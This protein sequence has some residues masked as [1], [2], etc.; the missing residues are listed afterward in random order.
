MSLSSSAQPHRFH[1]LRLPQLGAETLLLRDVFD[2]RDCLRVRLSPQQCRGDLDRHDLARLGPEAV[3]GGD[4]HAIPE[5]TRQTLLEVLAILCMRHRC[6]GAL[7]QLEDGVAEQAAQSGVDPREPQIGRKNGHADRRAIEHGTQLRLVLT[8]GFLGQLP[9][10]AFGYLRQRAPRRRRQALEAILQNE[11][12]GAGFERGGGFF[13]TDGAGHH[14]EWDVRGQFDRHGQ[15]LQAVPARQRVIRDD[16]IETAGRQRAAERRQR[17][18]PYDLRGDP[19]GGQPSRD[20]LAVRLAV[21]Q[22]KDL[23]AAHAA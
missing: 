12:R 18:D 19:F 7:V 10:A 16:E 6:E 3:L 5:E 14:K 13:F 2:H 9:L 4:R 8:Q 1:L 22:M 23:Q 11:V 21:L 17:G 20:Q 15:R